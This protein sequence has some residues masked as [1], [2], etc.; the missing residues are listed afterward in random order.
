[1]TAKK[2]KKT[3]K[4]SETD[5][6]A[7]LQDAEKEIANLRKDLV[8]ACTKA[9]EALA[10]MFGQGAVSGAFGEVARYLEKD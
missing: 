6:E 2:A 10:P 9:K 8:E 5:L 3:A 1:M 4:P 7:R